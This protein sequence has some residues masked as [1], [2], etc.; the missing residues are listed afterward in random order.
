MYARSYVHMY[1]RVA[2]QQFEI[3]RI[4]N[5]ILWFVYFLKIQLKTLT[6]SS[7]TWP[8]E[9]MVISYWSLEKKEFGF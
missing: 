3:I 4:S 9:E 7:Y 2:Q 6:N 1:I 5:Y 8:I